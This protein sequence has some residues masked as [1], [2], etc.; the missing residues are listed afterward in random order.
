MHG[1]VYE[2]YR[3]RVARERIATKAVSDPMGMR[4]SSMVMKV[5]SAKVRSGV[6][7]VGWTW[8]V[9]VSFVLGRLIEYI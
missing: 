2:M 6:R 7:R 5:V 1:T 3:A 8:W 4:S 9:H